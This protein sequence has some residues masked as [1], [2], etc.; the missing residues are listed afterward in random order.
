MIVNLGLPYLLAFRAMHRLMAPRDFLFSYL[1]NVHLLL[2]VYRHRVDC[3]CVVFYSMLSEMGSEDI[4]YI[5]KG[6][7]VISSVCIFLVASAL[8]FFTKVVL[9]RLTVVMSIM[10]LS[11]KHIG[12][13][14]W[15]AS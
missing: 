1:V 2:L 15:G 7:A 8:S 14:E 3:T 11:L 13:L 4:L 10:T 5:G 6:R 12:E 9:G